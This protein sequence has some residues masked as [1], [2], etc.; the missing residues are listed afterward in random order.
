MRRIKTILSLVLA[1]LI[2]STV[3]VSFSG[4]GEEADPNA[5]HEVA[6]TVYVSPDGS[7]DSKDG[8]KEAPFRTLER[9][10]EYVQKLKKNKGDI[11]VEIADGFYELEDT[12]VFNEDDSGT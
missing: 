1:A 2:L 5:P 4:C 11:I 6:Y 12:L 3:L 10:K 7:D 9:A 8:S